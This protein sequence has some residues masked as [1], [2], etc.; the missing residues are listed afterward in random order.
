MEVCI[1]IHLSKICLEGKYGGDEDRLLLS[2]INN[3]LSIAVVNVF[4]R[5]FLMCE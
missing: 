2:V 3:G 5:V 4:K 1:T